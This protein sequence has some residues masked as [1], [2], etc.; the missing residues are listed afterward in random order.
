MQTLQS[1]LLAQAR[2]DRDYRAGTYYHI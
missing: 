2:D 1:S